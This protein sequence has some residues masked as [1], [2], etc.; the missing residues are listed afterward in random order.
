MLIYSEWTENPLK[1]LFLPLSNAC[2]V[3]GVF[4]RHNGGGGGILP[5]GHICLHAVDALKYSLVS[6]YTLSKITIFPRIFISFVI[7]DKSWEV[8]EIGRE[9]GRE[10][11]L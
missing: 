7:F 9:N 4:N 10:D 2:L 11:R 8:F 6:V 3:I 5:G 1:V